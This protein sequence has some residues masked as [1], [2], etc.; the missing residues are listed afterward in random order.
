MSAE[1]GPGSLPGSSRWPGVG[2][3]YRAPLPSVC[4]P[5]S[6]TAVT[7]PGGS[8]PRPRTGG[9]APGW[10]RPPPPAARAE[11]ERP[12]PPAP[13]CTSGT[14]LGHIC[15]ASGSHCPRPDSPALPCRER[16]VPKLPPHT[17]CPRPTAPL[18]SLSAQSPGCS[19]SLRSPGD[20][21]SYRICL[22]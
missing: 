13:G 8:P 22:G 5:C 15:T 14:H 20:L 6:L 19:R 16:P 17:Q 7:S 12:L 18:P 4:G 2:R 21:E 11:H 1:A 9:T 3:G 10:V